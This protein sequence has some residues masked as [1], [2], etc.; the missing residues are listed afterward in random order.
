VRAILCTERVGERSTK[1]I[2]TTPLHH[3]H[4]CAIGERLVVLSR[5]SGC[6]ACC[7]VNR[8][9]QVG[10]GVRSR[11]AH[12]S[13]HS[14]FL[15][16]VFTFFRPSTGG[17]VRNKL[18]DNVVCEKT[19]VDAINVTGPSATMLQIGNEKEDT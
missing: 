14:H 13:L 11:A 12:P 7:V 4:N 2:G 3:V 16:V 17:S 1:L 18:Q 10:R 19:I 5:K 8:G 9:R 6:L 15:V